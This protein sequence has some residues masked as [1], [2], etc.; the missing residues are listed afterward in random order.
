ML[1]SMPSKDFDQYAK[2]F[3]ELVNVAR[4]L[5]MQT[6]QD[7]GI[8][9]PP[10]PRGLEIGGLLETFKRL[11]ECTDVE[12]QRVIA[13]MNAGEYG[14]GFLYFVRACWPNAVGKG[15]RLP[16]HAKA[17]GDVF[18]SMYE[19]CLHLV[20][21]FTP[22]NW[23][24]VGLSG[25]A[26]FHHCVAEVAMLGGFMVMLDRL[27]PPTKGTELA[28]QTRAGIQKEALKSYLKTRISKIGDP[29][30]SI[31]PFSYGSATVRLGL[32]GV[33]L[34]T[35]AGVSQDDIPVQ[36]EL[37]SFKRALRTYVDVSTGKESGF[38]SIGPDEVVRQ[39]RSPKHPPIRLISPPNLEPSLKELSLLVPKVS[40]G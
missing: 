30:V 38:V 14:L 3:K 19:L 28:E 11:H 16:S 34:Q 32:F 40:S 6:D 17:L 24:V 27:Y 15:L 33:L 13:S 25:A 12:S 31:A 8:T 29:S 23:G 39:Q 4:Y 21:Y 10:C 20:D 22:K 5:G 35:A 37:V 36:K 2:Q 18:C 1:N 7:W 26:F 9:Y